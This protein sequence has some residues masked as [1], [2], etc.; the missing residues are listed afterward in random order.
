MPPHLVTFCCALFLLTAC[1]SPSA[2][3]VSGET[4]GTS[5][6]VELAVPADYQGDTADIDVKIADLLAEVNAQMSTY[7]E[8]SEISRFNAAP[9]DGWVPVSKAL[10]HLVQASYKLHRLSDGA[11]DI[12]VGPLVN[13]WGFGPIAKNN[14]QAEGASASP[15][16]DARDIATAMRHV[17]LQHLQVRANPP[18]LYK[19]IPLSLD[20]SAMAKGYGVDVI[21]DML[22]ARN[23]HNYLVEIGGEIR[24]HGRNSQGQL[25]R[26]GIERPDS[27]TRSAMYSIELAEGAI[28]TSGNYRNFFMHEDALYAHIIDARTGWPMQHELASVTVLA[29]SGMYADGLAT[30][31]YTLGFDQ[32]VAL[33]KTHDLAVLLIAKKESEGYLEYKTPPF[34]DAMQ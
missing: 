30:T 5:Y 2:V 29:D 24:V 17:G 6:H 3:R 28:A 33:A 7:V 13:L 23:L 16:P 31:L 32:A 18:A 11:F 21:A 4:M 12:T 27:K 9:I 15:V 14:A 22:T 8:D 25:W 19:S 34:L 1:G 10:L 26:I 20:V